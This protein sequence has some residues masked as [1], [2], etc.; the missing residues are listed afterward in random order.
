MKAMHVVCWAPIVKTEGLKGF[1]LPV[2]QY[3][4]LVKGNL[5][6]IKAIILH[7]HA[8]TSHGSLS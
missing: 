2:R 5:F 7:K 8:G 4:L 6:L 3:S 1:E